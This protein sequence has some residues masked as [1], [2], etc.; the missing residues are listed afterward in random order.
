MKTSGNRVEYSEDQPLRVADLRAEQEFLVTLEHRHNLTLHSPGI[1][2][3]LDARE[4]L[5]GTLERQ[6]GVAVDEEGRLLVLENDQPIAPSEGGQ[7]VDSWLL[8]CEAPLR[9]RRPGCVPCGTEAFD[10]WREFVLVLDTP[11]DPG[12]E[13]LAPAPSAVYLGR[14][15]C[16]PTGGV[17][18]LSYAGLIAS[19]AAGPQSDV[20]MT[21]GP[22]TEHAREGFSVGASGN[23]NA[24]LA[25]DRVG[26]NY[27][28]GTV[29]LSEYYPSTAVVLPG[30]ETLVVRALEPGLAGR[31]YH[32]RVLPQV[33]GQA[34]S[35]QIQFFSGMKKIGSPLAI[36]QSSDPATIL[37]NFN[38]QHIALNL[39]GP[40]DLVNPATAKGSPGAALLGPLTPPAVLP[41]PPSAPAQPPVA[42]ASGDVPLES[43]GSLLELEDWPARQDE[44]DSQPNGLS[45]EA[46]AATPKAPPFPGTYSVQTGTGAEPAQ[47]FR[48]DLGEKRDNDVTVRLSIGKT[49]SAEKGFQDWVQMTGLCA[50]N[51]GVPGTKPD[52]K[53][54]PVMLKI[55]GNLQPAPIKPSLADQNFTTLMVL[56]WL[57]G[58]QRSLQANTAV[59]ISFF[60]PPSPLAPP[61]IIETGKP[62]S[63]QVMITNRSGRAITVDGIVES[64]T[65]TGQ[66]APPQRSISGKVQ[67]PVNGQKTFLVDHNPN[68]TPEGDL[69]IE[70]RVFGSIGNSHWWNSNTTG[71]IPVV[72][73]PVIDVDGFPDSVPPGASW[74]QS[75]S[76]DNKASA[77]DLTLNAVTI[78]EGPGAPQSLPGTPVVV[79]KSGSKSFGP[80][81]H[82]GASADVKFTMHADFTWASGVLSMLEKVK[83]VRITPDLSIG[84]SVPANLPVNTAWTFD[85]KLKNEGSEEVR[86]RSLSQRIISVNG[87]FL[88]IA[89]PTDAIIA[90]DTMTIRAIDGI[91]VPSAPSKV[92]LEID[93]TYKRGHRNFHP[94]PATQEIGVV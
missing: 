11:V 86:L 24:W 38:L 60:A 32:L 16:N 31:K 27:L 48:L 6:P 30:G 3:G 2:L 44:S 54:L 89:L 36:G 79:P 61:P 67:I 25:I 22:E 53:N 83:T 91:H 94:S 9:I 40:L 82:A 80:L 64:Q 56:A 66:A 49:D 85:L 81:S 7:C 88:P 47:Q 84:F 21:V 87:D 52:P 93:V 33:K 73:Q 14:T 51:I 62:W 74:D 75:F 65:I 70:V 18:D 90:G 23:S 35:L 10:R 26:S 69:T 39:V 57:A 92:T 17:P 34:S 15:Q 78:T 12:A 45:F 55:T 20:V 13:P 68:N 76:F 59:D 72:A 1:L 58:L 5:T 43:S 42:E 28:N 37:K 71:P 4:G 8:F 41:A 46:M 50:V 29:T 77:M 63:Y 19:K